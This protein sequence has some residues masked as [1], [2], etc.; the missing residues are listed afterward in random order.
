MR[1]V[2]LG[3]PM[4]VDVHVDVGIVR[5]LDLEHLRIFLGRDDVHLSYVQDGRPV[6]QLPFLA[7]IILQPVKR[8]EGSTH[9][10]VL[11][12]SGTLQEFLKRRLWRD[13]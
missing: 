10:G 3:V 6:A 2:F 5:K 9:F 8:L 1:K 7:L 4:G 11:P 12:E 13:S